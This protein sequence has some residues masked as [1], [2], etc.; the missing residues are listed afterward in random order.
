MT[1]EVDCEAVYTYCNIT[2]EKD[3]NLQNRV[4]V[5][6]MVATGLKYWPFLHKTKWIKIEPS[7]KTNRNKVDHSYSIWTCVFVCF[8]KVLYVGDRLWGCWEINDS[9][10]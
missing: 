3:I 1:V 6:G 9:V 5:T 8:L 4:E 7:F 2:D 10:L